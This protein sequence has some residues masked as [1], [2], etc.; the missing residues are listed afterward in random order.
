MNIIIHQAEMKY[1]KETGYIGNVQFQAEGHKEPYEITLHSKDGKEWSYG[2]HFSHEPGIE[3]EIYLVE[4]EIDEDDEFF[5]KLI[6][7]AKD[8][9]KM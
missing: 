6:Q 1:T 5:D 7:A 9:A 8:T 2:L 3:E 4:T